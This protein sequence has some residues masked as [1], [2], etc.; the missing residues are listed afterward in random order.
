MEQKLMDA[1]DAL[2]MDERCANKVENAM[3]R[4]IGTQTT[5]RPLWRSIAATVACLM[6]VA[7]CIAVPALAGTQ[8]IFDEFLAGMIER[9]ELSEIAE[10]E[11]LRSNFAAIKD[12]NGY[13]GTLSLAG[14]ADWLEEQDGRLYFT[15]NGEHI[16][17]TDKISYE[18]PFTYIYT[19]DEQI[20]HYIA[21]GGV[22][23]PD[24]TKT[25][26]GWCEYFQSAPGTEAYE[27]NAEDGWIGGYGHNEID[28][29]IDKQYPWSVKAMEEFDTPWND[30]ILR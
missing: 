27:P 10:V 24:P 6:L 19:D 2:H 15:A 14:P 28:C 4:R 22:Y 26:H 1:F 25:D 23:D 20:I 16:D 17:I 30:H 29:D 8:D 21:V 11:N 18:E 3:S 5:V 13:T 9:G 7:V 12:Q